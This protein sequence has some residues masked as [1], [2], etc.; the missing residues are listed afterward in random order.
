MADKPSFLDRIKTR[1]PSKEGEAQTMLVGA[2]RDVFGSPQGSLVLHDL[3]F[4]CGLM[5]VSGGDAGMQALVC[6]ILQTLRTSPEELQRLADRET[7]SDD[8]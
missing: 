2:Y 3:I 7:D 4:R 1:F 5:K 8:E 6:Y